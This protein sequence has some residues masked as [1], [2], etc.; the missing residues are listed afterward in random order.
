M[1]THD[2]RDDLLDERAASARIRGI[3]LGTLRAWRADG[4]GPAYHRR[5][6]RIYYTARDIDAWLERQRVE[7]AADGNLSERRTP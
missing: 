1:A 3:A 4:V 6:R 2:D 5:G 7:P